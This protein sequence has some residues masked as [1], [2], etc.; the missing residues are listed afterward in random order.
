MKEQLKVEHYST[1]N[2]A[3]IFRLPLEVFSGYVAYAHLIIHNN[4]HYLVDVGSGFGSSFKDLLSGLET[5]QRDHNIAASLDMLEMIIITHGHVD[6]FGGL[7]QVK[8]AAPQAKVAIHELDRPVL[9]NY[10][11]RVLVTSKGMAD[12]LQRGGVP[13][14]R[15]KRLMDMYMLGKRAFKSVPVDV[16][17]HDGDLIDNLFRVIHVPGHTSGLVMLQIEDVLLSADHLLPGTS[18]ALAPE[19]LMPYTGVGHYLDSLQ[20]AAKVE[21]VRLALGGHE[22]AMENYYDIAE[23]THRSSLEK[24]YKVLAACSEPRTIFELATQIYGELAG[25]SELLKIEQTGARI[26]YLNQRGLVMIDNLSDLEND[27]S[28]IIKYQMV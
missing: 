28:P 2:D 5:I 9:I 17:L 1:S 25:Y 6:H 4:R 3:A 20:K 24:V 8:E 18:V 11:E 26:E 16:T 12:F 7:M 22:W 27:A 14:D 15:R 23:R 19:A 13:E 21:G 10:D